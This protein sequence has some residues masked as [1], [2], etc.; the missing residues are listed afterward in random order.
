MSI[1]THITSLSHP[2]IPV[3][4]WIILHTKYKR[5]RW[6]N[7]PSRG[8]WPVKCRLWPSPIALQN[9][10]LDQMRLWSSELMVGAGLEGWPL[11]AGAAF[12]PDFWKQAKSGQGHKLLWN[13]RAAKHQGKNKWLLVVQYLGFHKNWGCGQIFW[14][15]WRPL[16]LT[17][18]MFFAASVVRDERMCP[19][20]SYGKES[21]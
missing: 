17:Q 14:T 8:S 4:S 21:R 13:T 10:T 1:S 19:I 2:F 7:G 18:T 6:P 15:N 12:I 3:Q 20:F 5:Q 11:M 9:S 16:V